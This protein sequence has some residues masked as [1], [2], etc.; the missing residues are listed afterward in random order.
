MDRIIASRKTA[1]VSACLIGAVMATGLIATA[2]ASQGGPKEYEINIETTVD[3]GEAKTSLA[4]LCMG[5]SQLKAP[6][7]K[8]TGP[9][10]PGQLFQRSGDTMTWK[11][12]C[13]G[14]NGSG[15]LTFASDDSR[16]SGESTMTVGGKSVHTKVDATAVDTCTL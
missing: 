4:Y 5:V 7:E 14:A 9:R 12:S 1:F 11:A 16:F 2:V 3:G 8:I 15:Q 13:A 6:P 10:C